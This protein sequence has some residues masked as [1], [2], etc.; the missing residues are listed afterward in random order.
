IIPD[1]ELVLV[2][3]VNPGFGGQEFIP[4]S[5]GKIKRVR[6][7]LNQVKPEIELEVDGGVDAHSTP[8]AV[9]AGARVLVAGSSVFGAKDGIAAGMAALRKA[10]GCG[11]SPGHFRPRE[12]PWPA[13]NRPSLSPAQTP[14]SAPSFAV[15]PKPPPAPP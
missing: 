15:P 3:T 4:A 12:A 13:A 2:M 8:G 11:R 5:L 1:V 14:P 7:M 10:A 9:E 6:Q